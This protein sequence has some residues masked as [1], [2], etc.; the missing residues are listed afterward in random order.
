[1][2]ANHP[3]MNVAALFVVDEQAYSNSQM[4]ELMLGNRIESPISECASK[5]KLS[6]GRAE[7]LG[8]KVPMHPRNSK[9]ASSSCRESCSSLVAGVDVPLLLPL[10]AWLLPP[11]D[12]HEAARLDGGVGLRA[13]SQV[14]KMGHSA[15]IGMDRR[16][17][18]A[19]VE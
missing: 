14:T 7:G 18:D 3:V 19:A 10:A 16:K 8:A 4:R 2:D 6:N 1:M 13:L 9:S 12:S 15:V 11:P 5:G 17:F